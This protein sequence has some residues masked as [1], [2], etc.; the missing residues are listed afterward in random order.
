MR[1]QHRPM[2][3]VIYPKGYFKKQNIFNYELNSDILLTYHNSF[4]DGV[5]LNAAVGGNMMTSKLD[6]LSNAANGL[7]TP[8]VYKL[9]NAISAIEFNQKIL[10][11]RVNS[12]YF[13][14]NLAYK[15]KLFLDISGR[16]DWSSTLPERN[17]SFFYSS[18]SA[19]VLFNE[20]FNMPR[21]INLLKLRASWAQVGN[22]T[23]PY[24]TSRYYETTNFAGSV[25][26]PTTLF[27]ADFKPEIS[28]NYEVGMDIRTFGNRLNVDFAYYYNPKNQILDAPMDPTTGYSKATIN[29]G[30][31]QNMGFE[32][33]LNFIPVITN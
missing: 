11:K 19:S 31:V 32:E 6:M 1:E 16:N 5:T 33:A 20:W 4:L 12:V 3:D 10:N 18:V 13:T 15:N 7:I 28:T 14:A 25:K 27:N 22:D 17:N 21:E 2:S 30:T 29:S 23:D 8:G 26:L 24:K 9:A